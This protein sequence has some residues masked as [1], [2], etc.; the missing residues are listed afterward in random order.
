[1][2]LRNFSRN[3]KVVNYEMQEENVNAQQENPSPF[4]ENSNEQK[5]KKGFM[6][7]KKSR[8]FG[9]IFSVVLLSIGTTA[10]VFMQLFNDRSEFKKLYTAYD[11]LN[12]MYFE[13]I[14]TE[15]IIEGAIDGMLSSLNDPYSDYMNREEAKSFHENI[16]SSFEGI[17]AEVQE[18]DGY[19][20]IVSPI[21]GSPAEKAG[22]QPNDKV[23][24]ADGESLQGMS[25]TEAVK[26][27][28]GEKGTKVTVTIEREGM[29]KPMDFEITR[30]TIPIE[31]VYG[32]MLEDGIAK[33]QITSFSENTTRELVE[34][35]N[36]LQEQGM[37]GLVL[38]L[39]QNP[40]GLLPR[41]V[42]ISSLFVPK[43]KVLF[44]VEDRNGNIEEYTSTNKS[45]PKIPLVVV[46]N[47][48]S[49]SASE[50]LAAAVKES[51]G[52]PL[53]GE[54][55]FGKGTVQNAK[56]FKDGSNMKL[57]TA[58]WLTPNGNWIHQKGI[59][60]DYEV[61]LP[62]YAMLPFLNPHVEI[63]EGA[64]SFEVSIA[65]QM[66]QAL[67]Y[68]T[69]REDGLFDEQMKQAVIAF[70]KDV[71]LEPTGIIKG[72]TAMNIM[73]KLQEKATNEDTQ[74]EKAVEVLQKQLNK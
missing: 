6:T 41:A 40:G 39:R 43:G 16:E 42:E 25:A 64:T 22:L 51:A 14:D 67:G 45:E 28:R 35:L 34:T 31:T 23:L 21:K 68:K 2:V 54:T 10:M 60:P 8:F 72:Q 19:I 32:E 69:G 20:I 62:D 4:E 29:D 18:Q 58:K 30:D 17:G 12:E 56:D 26:H 63:K 9:I 48:G 27:I 74:L 36:D 5:Q 24:A 70:Q 38:D 53:V 55:S 57:T 73:Q 52:V 7:L 33:V 66:L 1:M 49:A 11:S 50:I 59:K 65:Q 71:G 46:I 44:K 15:K 47:K 61:S 37:K 3:R 13:T